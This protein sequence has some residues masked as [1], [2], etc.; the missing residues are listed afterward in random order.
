[1][2][3]E[4][5]KDKKKEAKVKRP[6]AQKRILQSEKNRLRNRDMKSRVRTAI[7]SLEASLE[8][9]GGKSTDECMSEVYSLID[10]AVKSGVWKINKASRIKS[11]LMARAAA[12]A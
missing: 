10:K 9:T 12:K 3:A 7:R 11:R 2:M 8:G 6:T 5:K 1:M 4:D